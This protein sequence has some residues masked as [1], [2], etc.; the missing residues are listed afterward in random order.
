MGTFKAIA[1]FAAATTLSF[2]TTAATANHNLDNDASSAP[3][4]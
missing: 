2:T 1:I 3:N 4:I